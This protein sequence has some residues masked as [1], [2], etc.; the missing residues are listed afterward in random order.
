MI[1]SVSCGR[2]VRVFPY[3]ICVWNRLVTLPRD[4]V[5]DLATL[6]Q[7]AFAFAYFVLSILWTQ[8]GKVEVKIELTAATPDTSAKFEYLPD[9]HPLRKLRAKENLEKEPEFQEP[10]SKLS[11]FLSNLKRI[12]ICIALFHWHF[13][14]DL[15][16]CLREGFGFL[17]YLL[18]PFP[19]DLYA[20][21]MSH[22]AS[23][24]GQGSAGDMAWQGAGLVLGTVGRIPRCGL[25]GL[26]WAADKITQAVEKVNMIVKRSQEETETENTDAVSTNKSK[27]EDSKRKSSSPPLRPIIQQ[28][29]YSLPKN[30][31]TK[32]DQ[33]EPNKKDTE[34]I[35]ER[36]PKNKQMVVP[37]QITVPTK[38]IEAFKTEVR[39]QEEILKI[40][41]EKAR[42]LFSDPVIVSGPWIREEKP[43]VPGHREEGNKKPIPMFQTSKSEMGDA[44]EKSG[45]FEQEKEQRATKS[46][47]DEPIP[48]S[49]VFERDSTKPEFEV[50]AKV[51]TPSPKTSFT[52]HE[53][54]EQFGV[55]ALSGNI[56]TSMYNIHTACEDED[57]NID[58][59]ENLREPSPG[60]DVIE[61]RNTDIE[62]IEV[63][64]HNEGLEDDSLISSSDPYI[65]KNNVTDFQKR[66]SIM[67]E[68]PRESPDLKERFS[69]KNEIAQLR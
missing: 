41:K 69:V 48:T 44:T 49:S 38:N 15:L 24:A 51:Q 18:Y 7:D 22:R 50:R 36:A 52:K 37:Q 17:F 32:E 61:Y 68:A 10:E 45:L 5:T 54:I 56:N 19:L 67:S 6:G 64:D 30:P 14:D 35:I 60:A 26:T 58:E 40:G 43:F 2:L 66:S 27:E 59:L 8:P 46:H 63:K 11:G 16:T 1:F 3:Y 34:Q 13:Y 21:V 28:I 33:R 57:E 62:D 39:I 9:N 12:A 47:F 55:L 65:R 20:W 29:D 4:F 42:E 23:R 53:A 31:R 25:D